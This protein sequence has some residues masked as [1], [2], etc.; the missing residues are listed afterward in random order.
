VVEELEEGVAAVASGQVRINPRG[1]TIL[2]STHD[3]IRGGSSGL[4]SVGCRFPAADAYRVAVQEQALAVG[5]VLAGKG[6]VS[7]NSLAAL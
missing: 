4:A 3:E 2:T 5:R 1:Q 6:L 7:S